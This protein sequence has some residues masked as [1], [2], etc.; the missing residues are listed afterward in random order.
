M[1]GRST[2]SL[3]LTDKFTFCRNAAC[4]S[5]VRF[6]PGEDLVGSTKRSSSIARADAVNRGAGTDR[7]YLPDDAAGDLPIDKAPFSWAIAS[8]LELTVSLH[9]GQRTVKGP[10]GILASS[11]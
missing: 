11:T 1:S 4:L 8:A 9:F 2:S 6:A 7:S 10:V 5:I 3:K